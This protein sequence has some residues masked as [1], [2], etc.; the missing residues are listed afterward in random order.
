M[1]VFDGGLLLHEAPY[2]YAAGDMF[3]FAV[4]ADFAK[5]EDDLTH[6]PT[7]ISQGIGGVVTTFSMIGSLIA[8][9]LALFIGAESY[10]F[11]IH[12]SLV[13]IVLSILIIFQFLRKIDLRL[14]ILAL[15]LSL[16]VFKWP[17]QYTIT[18][19]MQLS[20]INMLFVVVSLFCLLNLNKRYM[21]IVLGIMNGAGFLAHARETLMFNTCVALYFLVR[22][23]KEKIPQ[24][25]IKNPSMIKTMLKENETVISFK[26]Y[27]F[28]IPI[29]LLMM[30]RYLPL[31]FIF[32]YNKSPIVGHG[33][34]SYLILYMPPR[35]RHHVYF[36]QFGFFEYLIYIG[37]IIGLYFLIFKKSRIMDIIMAF[38]IM[39][40]LSGFFSILSN[41]TTQIRHLFPILLIPLV[42]ITLFVLYSSL[43]KTI[44]I[45]S[46]L[47]FLVLFLLVLIPTAAYHSPDQVSEYAF[48]DPYTWEGIRW[49]RSNVGDED[50]VVIL[51][52]DRH[53]QE[54]MFYMML[55]NQF[56]TYRESYL[57]KVSKNILSSDIIT[58]GIIMAEF[59]VKNGTEG[60][61]SRDRLIFNRKNKSICDYDYVYSDKI[62][63]YPEV[64]EYTIRLMKKLIDENNFV[65]VFQN[66][67]V[68]ILKN[69]NVGGPCFKDEVL[70]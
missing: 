40:V 49:V 35:L 30:F 58:T 45:K 70:S 3:T 22:F 2:N 23:L 60:Y 19:G 47:I 68:I 56:R 26:N 25:I 10:D 69:N 52:G 34:G 15:P 13:F 57:D 12:L 7:Y 43:K 38:G 42:G 39:F 14:A 48:S 54:S 44:K 28:S 11:I 62:S 37:V 29:M 67:L 1:A 59:I 61:V 65:V 63:I 8:A 51:Y 16:L 24:E 53:G 32:L 33:I 4:Y 31:L 18:W 17:F 5:F 64:Q 41:K 21:F 55:K 9:Q 20:N 66:D 50:K 46:A 36:P 27:L 6:V